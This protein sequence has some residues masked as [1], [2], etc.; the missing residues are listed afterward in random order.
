MDICIHIPD[1]PRRAWRALL[2]YVRA[3][4]SPVR[5][6]GIADF[7]ERHRAAMSLRAK[8]DAANDKIS[9]YRVKVESLSRELSEI[10]RNQK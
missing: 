2:Y 7:R 4:K 1:S 3:R 9:A 8:L 6:F 10:K 5:I